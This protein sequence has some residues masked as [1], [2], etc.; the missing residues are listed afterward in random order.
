MSVQNPEHIRVGDV[1]ELT[2]DILGPMKTSLDKGT[3]GR[4][5]RI[6]LGKLRAR[7]EFEVPTGEVIWLWPCQ[8]PLRLLRKVP[9]S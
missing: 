9:S 3:K 7:V 8:C 5:L 6:E 2:E 1:V 4:V